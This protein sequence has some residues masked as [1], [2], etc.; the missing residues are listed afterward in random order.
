MTMDIHALVGAYALDAVDDLERAAF[1]R[2]VAGCESCRAELD[3]LRETSA[4]LADGAW[5]VPPPRLRADVLGAIARTR[6][7]P[8]PVSA[9]PVRPAVSAGNR[10][11]WLVAAAAATLLAG[12]AST[13]VYSVQEQRVRDQRAVAEAAEQRETRTRAILAAP[14]VVVRTAPITGGGKVTVATSNLQNAGVVLLGADA[15]PSRDRVYQLWTVRGGKAASAGVL[16]A[17]QT[18]DVRIIEGLPGTA[19]VGVTVEPAGGSLTPTL[20]MVSD[21]QLI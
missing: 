9:P 7:L 14:D 4:R 2:H 1:E 16:A 17:G 6:Q 5:S 13:A 10:R 3:E 11:R 18:T 8:P 21:V 19:T 15:P 20:P 12:G